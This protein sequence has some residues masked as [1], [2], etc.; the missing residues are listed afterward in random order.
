MSKKVD[1]AVHGPGWGEVI[2]GAVL[3]L[4]LGVVL[5]AVLLMLKPV[6]TAKEPPK[7]SVAGAVY[8]IE[9]SHD[10]TKA[11]QALAKR[12]AF[13][14]G[15]S[16]TATEDEINSLTAPA[17]AAA[18]K[19]AEKGKP[20]DKAAPASENTGLIT[21]GTP[22]VRIRN[23]V[24]QIGVPVTIAALGFDQKVIVQAHG[25]FTKDGDVFVFDST[26]LYVGA[27]PVQRL[28][29]LAGYVRSKVLAAQPIPEDIATAWR[30]LASV[31]VDGN[32]LKLAMP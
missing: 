31:S 5:G 23:G 12:K 13:V 30:K 8:Y 14:A 3:S 6:I 26:D 2:L 10:T 16:V 25:G 24:V 18:P 32:A 9:G 27:C 22:N 4:V 20:A 28:P 11:K 17:P 21:P 1:R 7:E 29:F 15:Q 19:P